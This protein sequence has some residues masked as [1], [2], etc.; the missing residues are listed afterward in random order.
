MAEE[1]GSDGDF[2]RW[3]TARYG[4]AVQVAGRI[5]GSHPLGE[6]L[7]QEAFARA[8]ARWWRV[9]RLPH[10]DAWVM[11]VTINLALRKVGS[12]VALPEVASIAPAFDE[13]VVR[14]TDLVR[15]L[16]QLPKRQRDVLAPPSSPRLPLFPPP[17]RQLPPPWPPADALLRS[18]PAAGF[19]MPT[20]GGCGG[21]RRSRVPPLRR[22]ALRRAGALAVRRGDGRAGLVSRRRREAED[23]QQITDTRTAG[24]GAGDVAGWVAIYNYRMSKLLPDAP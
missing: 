4:Q 8:H 3:F 21:P 14:R 6:D 20:G 13:L 9:G 22:G 17:H 19:D 5:V 15:A 2:E 18:A 23:V 11:R 12:A 16:A 7:A 24:P 10:R 1:E